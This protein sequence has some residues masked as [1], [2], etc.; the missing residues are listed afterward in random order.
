MKRDKR[1]KNDK[2][3]YDLIKIKLNVNNLHCKI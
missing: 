2:E 1:L 3:I